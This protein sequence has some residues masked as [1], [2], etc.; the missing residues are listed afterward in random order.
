MTNNLKAI[1]NPFRSPILTIAVL[2]VL[3]VVTVGVKARVWR[4]SA[5]AVTNP[6]QLLPVERGPAQMVRF[7]V[8]DAGI[9]PRE[10]RVSAGLVSLHIEDMSGGS[11]GLVVTSEFLQ[12]VAQVIRRSQRWRDKARVSLAPGRYTVYDASQPGHRA[13]LIVEP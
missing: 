8:Y 4:N 1:T 3:V 12:P 9:F 6:Q 2:A 10:V 13:T 11:A 5:P 7:T